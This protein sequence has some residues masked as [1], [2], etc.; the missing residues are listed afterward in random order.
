MAKNDNDNAKILKQHYKEVFNRSIPV[1]LSVLEGIK[2]LPSIEEYRIASSKKERRIAISSMKHN[3]APGLT[4]L[5]TDMTK[6][7][8]PEGFNLL[9]DLIWDFWVNKEMDFKSW[10]DTKFLNL[11]QGKGNQQDHNNW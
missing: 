1:D 2:Q 9:S 5:T 8:P 11:L 3:K 6:S 7:L 4:G 10:H